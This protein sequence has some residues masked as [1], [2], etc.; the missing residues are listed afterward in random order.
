MID[1]LRNNLLT[2]ENLYS[3]ANRKELFKVQII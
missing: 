1:E 2:K 3:N